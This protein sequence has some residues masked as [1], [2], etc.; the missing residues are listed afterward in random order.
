MSE[1][2]TRVRRALVTLP[3][4]VWSV[5]D[6]ELIGK[7]GDGYSEVIR[8][9]VIAYLTEKGY[10]LSMKA[11]G[12]NMNSVAGELDIHDAMIT[13]LAELL[14]EKGGLNYSEWENR[15]KKKLK[16]DSKLS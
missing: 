11:K 14:E 10:L 12:A 6:K 5:I 15:V 2:G 3:D 8:N 9:L 1:K 16:E 4:G 13:A 7:L